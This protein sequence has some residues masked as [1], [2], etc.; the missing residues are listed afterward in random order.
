MTMLIRS[1]LQINQQYIVEG[2]T[3]GFFFV[4]GEHWDSI[5]R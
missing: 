5:T 1:I 3:G 2:F 4:L